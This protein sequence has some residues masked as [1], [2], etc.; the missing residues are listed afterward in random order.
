[1]NR[2]ARVLAYCAWSISLM[3]CFRLSSVVFW[4]SLSSF[5]FFSLLLKS[6]NVFSKIGLTAVFVALLD[7]IFVAVVA[8][9]L[10]LEALVELVLLLGD[11]V[12]SEPFVEMIA[13]LELPA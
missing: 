3:V 12:V 1:M 4:K 8:L 5:F 11:I 10:E 6:A 9:R 7:I 13:V 2:R